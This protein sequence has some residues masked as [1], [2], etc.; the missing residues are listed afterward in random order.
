MVLMYMSRLLA[1]SS[2]LTQCANVD[3]VKLRRQWPLVC[4]TCSVPDVEHVEAPREVFPVADTAANAHLV[5]AIASWRAIERHEQLDVV[6]Q[7]DRA[8]AGRLRAIERIGDVEALTERPVALRVL[9]S[10][11]RAHH[12]SSPGRL[13]ALIIGSRCRGQQPRQNVELRADSRRRR[14]GGV[15]L[16]FELD[17]GERVGP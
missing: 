14:Q 7:I 12:Y 15:G 11:Q 1:I 4:M 2:E 6:S 3:R 8:V 5:D 10:D 17:F 16:T 13:L 9:K